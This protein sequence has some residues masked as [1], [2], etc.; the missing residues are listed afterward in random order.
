M[1]YAQFWHRGTSGRLIP[2]CGSDSVLLIDGR[3]G[4]ARQVRVA[5]ERLAALAVRGYEAYTLHVGANFTRS[6][7]LVSLPFTAGGEPVSAGDVSPAY[8]ERGRVA[9]WA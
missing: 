1:I 9:A 4:P 6:R 7:P 2:A 5:R 3:F 8:L